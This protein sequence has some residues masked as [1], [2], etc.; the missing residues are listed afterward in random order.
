MSTSTHPTDEHAHTNDSALAL[1]LEKKHGYGSQTL[2]GGL[3]HTTQA[4]N[5][6][7]LTCAT[8][9]H[10]RR[11]KLFWQATTYTTGATLMLSA[12]IWSSGRSH[13]VC[14]VRRL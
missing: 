2:G 5:D 11:N 4:C 6:G 7:S 1:D 9:K 3:H 8:A 13:V 14:P 10:V 12:S